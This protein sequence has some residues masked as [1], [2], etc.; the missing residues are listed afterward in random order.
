MIKSVAIAALLAAPTTETAPRCVSKRQI[1]D[2]A[3][4]FAPMAVD[5]VREKCQPHLP[6][7]AFLARQGT[8]LVARL[9]TESA[10]RETSAAEVFVAA[11][12]AEAPPVKD[13]QALMQ[14]MGDMTSGMMVKDLHPERCA[15]V[16]G[17]IE[18]L[19]P[20]PAENIGLLV[21]SFAGLMES[22]AKAG[23]GKK[24]KAKGIDGFTICKNG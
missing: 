20:L 12:G 24:D 3:M 9:K 19:A 15:N 5:A 2:A 16:S 21:A 17:M 11:M 18:A 7:E 4:V 22:E 10:G 13:R 6:A 23:K 1:A 14:T 8:A